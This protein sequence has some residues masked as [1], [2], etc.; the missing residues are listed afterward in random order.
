M[1]N[2]QFNTSHVRPVCET[3]LRI[4]FRE[5]KECNGWG[6]IDGKKAVRIT[7]PKGKKPIAPKTYKSMATL[8]KLSVEEFDNLL[9]CPLSGDRYYELLRLRVR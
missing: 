3:K 8:L 1:K 9:E 7:I 5:G 4:H 2:S 6:S